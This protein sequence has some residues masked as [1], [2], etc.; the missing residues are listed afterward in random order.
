MSGNSFGAKDK[1]GD[2]EIFRLDALHR[3]LGEERYR[4]SPLLRSRAEA[5]PP[6]ESS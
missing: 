5:E 4:V 2:H 3:S 6:A 1:L